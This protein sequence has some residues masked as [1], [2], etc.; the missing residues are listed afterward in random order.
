VTA[1]DVDPELVRR[2]ARWA[3]RRYERGAV[4]LEEL[5][6]AARL[7]VVEAY[8]RGHHD[9][10]QLAVAARSGVVDELRRHIGRNALLRFAL[11]PLVA[12][13]F[14]APRFAD[15]ETGAAAAEVLEVAR[16]VRVDPIRLVDALGVGGSFGV[17]V[18]REAGRIRYRLLERQ[19]DRLRISL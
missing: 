5:E 6:D 3:A 18:E 9:E 8:A 10:A 7:A 15:P 1:E 19:R 2:F 12:D 11:A 14:H 4:E 16:A 17:G 13:R